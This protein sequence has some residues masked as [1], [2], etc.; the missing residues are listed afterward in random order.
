MKPRPKSRLRTYLW[1]IVILKMLLLYGLWFVLIKP[2]KVRVEPADIQQIYRVAPVV[3]PS[4]TPS[5]E[6][7]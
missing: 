5:G 7:K 2:N 3:P 4:S 6:L 1:W